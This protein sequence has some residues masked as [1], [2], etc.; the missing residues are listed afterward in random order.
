MHWQWIGIFTVILTQW[1][2][3]LLSGYSTGRWINLTISQLQQSY[4]NSLLWL[5]DG[6][7]VSSTHNLE[8]HWCHSTLNDGHVA[9]N[10]TTCIGAFKNLVLASAAVVC[11]LTLVL[12]IIDRKTYCSHW[13]CFIVKMLHGTCC[14]D[15]QKKHS[16]LYRPRKFP[17]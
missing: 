1:N 14:H 7:V 5:L 9:A 13:W 17:I 8:V 11:V 4:A 12:R 16:C 15:S 3:N 6:Q 2:S 10:W